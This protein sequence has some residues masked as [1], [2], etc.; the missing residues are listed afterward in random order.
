VAALGCIVIV[1]VVSVP[2]NSSMRTPPNPGRT[3]RQVPTRDRRLQ[4]RVGRDDD[5]AGHVQ[6]AQNTNNWFPLSDVPTSLIPDEVTSKAV[7]DDASHEGSVIVT[8]GCDGVRCVPV[9]IVI[10]LIVHRAQDH[11]V[12]TRGQR[13][14]PDPGLRNRGRHR[15]PGDQQRLRRL[16]L[17][18][19][20]PISFQSAVAPA[21]HRRGHYFGY[22]GLYTSGQCPSRR[23]PVR[24][25]PE[26]AGRWRREW[27]DQPSSNLCTRTR[28]RIMC[29]GWVRLR[30]RSR[31]RRIDRCGLRVEGVPLWIDQWFLPSLVRSTSRPS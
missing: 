24:S 16:D 18:T 15:M 7:G 17:V 28:Y 29:I 26:S 3:F 1:G 20:R 5:H 13:L 19:V 27:P 6:A 30:L 10:K 22:P 9:D 8:L 4:R 14:G 25:T 2:H 11:R 23:R 21:R 12:D 31:S